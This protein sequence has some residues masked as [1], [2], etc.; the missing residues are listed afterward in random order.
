MNNDYSKLADE[1]LGA[2]AGAKLSGKKGELKNLID[3]PDGKSVKKMLESGGVD[4]K[5]AAQK[6]DINTLKETLSGILKTE[7]GARIA[8]QIMKM[9]K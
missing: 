2:D 4:L 7:E 3:T 6:G 5:R 9:M 1:F 8:E